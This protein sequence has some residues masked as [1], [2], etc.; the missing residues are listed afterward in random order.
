MIF[1]LGIYQAKY[2]ENLEKELDYYRSFAERERARAD[3]LHDQLLQDRGCLPATETTLL[4][5]EKAQKKLEE[6]HLDYTKQL[7]EMFSDQVE[8]HADVVEGAEE[9]ELIQSIGDD[10]KAILG[11]K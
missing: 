3:R 11:S 4:A 8:E 10:L 6:A 5:Q 1:G 2:V 9:S 7:E